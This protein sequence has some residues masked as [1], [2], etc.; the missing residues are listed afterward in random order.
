[1]ADRAQAQV[2]RAEQERLESQLHNQQ[3]AQRFQQQQFQLQQEQMANMR[4]TPGYFGQV[5]GMGPALQRHGITGQAA[6]S[7]AAGFCPHCGNARSPSVGT[8][9]AV[10]GNKTM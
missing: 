2:V 9:C 8:F 7:A 1:M 5:L 6:G 4:A 3:V 10:C